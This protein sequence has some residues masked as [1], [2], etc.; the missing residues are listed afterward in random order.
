MCKVCWAKLMTGLEIL[1]TSCSDK[2][3]RLPK[4]V[5][6]AS[7]GDPQSSGSG[8]RHVQLATRPMVGGNHMHH[9]WDMIQ[10]VKRQLDRNSC[11]LH[12]QDPSFML[13][14]VSGGIGGCFE[15]LHQLK[16]IRT[17]SSIAKVPMSRSDLL[18]TRIRV[19]TNFG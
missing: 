10:T 17:T 19:P 7:L 12:C 14:Y 9:A 18:E 16:S 2:V 13:C 4:A 5:W 3:N 11:A 6:S 15:G 1:S 8:S